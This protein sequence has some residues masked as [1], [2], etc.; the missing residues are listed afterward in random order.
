LLFTKPYKEIF[1]AAA[2]FAG[3]EA[4]ECW[5]CGDGRI[6]DVDG[7]KNSLMTPVLLDVTSQIPFEYRTDGGRGEYLTVN[8]WKELAEYIKNLLE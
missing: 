1:N 3:V 5:Y 2:N 8:H 7:A 6:P 4:T